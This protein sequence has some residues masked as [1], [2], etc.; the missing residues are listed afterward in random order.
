MLTIE[1][2]KL[3]EMIGGRAC[4]NVAGTIWFWPS[5]YLNSMVEIRPWNKGEKR[6]RERKIE[7]M[8]WKPM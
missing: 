4:G 6:W 7:N 5:L 1:K 2:S 8:R 3:P